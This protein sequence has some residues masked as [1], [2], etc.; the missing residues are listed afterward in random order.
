MAGIAIQGASFFLVWIDPGRAFRPGASPEGGLSLALSAAACLL[1]ASSASLALWA[2]ATLGKQWSFTARLLEGH[3][4]VVRGPYRFVR[5]PIY[6]AMLGM[7]WATGLLVA[8]PLRLLAATVIYGAGA[9]M[10][11]RSEERLLKDEFGPQ[12]DRYAR[13]VPAVVPRWRGKRWI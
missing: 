11:V 2:A 10:R 8:T 5:H 9:A 4:L 7:L 3:E 1:A 6:A 12:W 13:D